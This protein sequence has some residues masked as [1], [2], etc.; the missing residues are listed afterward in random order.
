[1]KKAKRITAAIMAAA[2]IPAGSMTASAADNSLWEKFLKYDLC[3]T[4]YTALTPEQKE[5][6]HFIF[7]TEQNSERT[8]RCERARRILAG[9][10]VGERLSAEQLAD[11]YGVWDKYGVSV[12]GWQNYIYCVPD[13]VYTDRYQL[14][15]YTVTDSDKVMDILLGSAEA[16]CFSYSELMPDQIFN[17]LSFEVD[18]TSVIPLNASIGVTEEGYLTTNLTS[19]G[20]AFNIG[21]EKAEELIRMITENEQYII[22]STGGDPIPE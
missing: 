10:D 20:L 14:K 3:I 15:L 16:E 18:M 4:D 19:G 11:S 8:L 12:Y 9:E 6:C 7:D 13:I 22:E 5:L 17:K 2:L 1:M 21:K